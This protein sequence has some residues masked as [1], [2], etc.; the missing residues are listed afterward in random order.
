MFGKDEAIRDPAAIPQYHVDYREKLSDSPAIRWTDRLTIDGTWVGNLFQF[1]QKV[2]LRLTADIK[3]PFQLSTDLFR[4]DDTIVHEAIREALVNALIH[5]DYRGL[6]GIVV[7]KYRDRFELSN[8]GSLLVSIEQLVLGGVSECRNKS[9]QIMFQ[10]IGGGE[11]AGSGMDKIRRGWASQQWRVPLI[12]T[13]MRPD[14]VKLVL[15]MVSLLPEKAVQNLRD[16][17]GVQF[18][19]L[20]SAERQAVVT[21]EAEGEVSNGRLQQIST[22]HPSDISQM[23]QRLVTRGFLTQFGKKRGATYQITP[24]T[25]EDSLVAGSDSTHSESNSTHSEPDSTH[26]GTDSTHSEPDSTHSGTDST[27]SEPDSTHSEP[28]ST[29]SEPDSTHSGSGGE[30]SHEQLATEIA[31]SLEAL[32]ADLQDLYARAQRGGRLAREDMCRLIIG[33]CQSRF[34][35]PRQLAGLLNRRAISLQQH[36]LRGMVE[37]GNLTLRYADEPNH[38]QQAYRATLKPVN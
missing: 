17:F 5:A 12:R 19:A 34:L 32:G 7:E 11:K 30:V 38:P 14:R 18:D 20:E 27:H 25:A 29:H 33:L 24:E 28:D 1:Y 23:L 35:T 13:Q 16:R 9:L 3:I 36:Y 8:P 21:A 4:R 37:S 26:S 2:I 15:P 31:T 22:D 10:M 6:G